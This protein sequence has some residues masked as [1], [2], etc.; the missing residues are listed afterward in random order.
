MA[1][2]IKNELSPVVDRVVYIENVPPIDKTLYTVILK[3]EF[4]FRLWGEIDEVSSFYPAVLIKLVK[5]N[6]VE[7]KYW[8]TSSLLLL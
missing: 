2:H 8:P 3:S 6:V 7:K 4:I 5:D 1:D